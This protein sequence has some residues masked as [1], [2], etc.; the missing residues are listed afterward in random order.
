MKSIRV[1]N[2]RAG[3]LAAAAAV[4]LST[5]LPAFASADQVTDRSIALSSSSMEATG[6]SYTV[7]FTPAVTA[8]AVV[9][10]FCSDSPVLGETC[11]APVGFSASSAATS[12]GFTM[13]TLTTTAPNKVL[14]TGTMTAATPLSIEL[15]NVTNPDN[16]GTMYAR[17]ITYTD[18]TGAIGYTSATPGTHL[19]DGGVALSITST[20]GVSGA[21]LESMTFCVSG[22]A[23]AD[24]CVTTT[25]PT[26]KLGE[27]TGGTVAL[28]AGT[29]SS[30]N[31]YTQISTNATNGAIVNLKSSAAGCGGLINS[32]KPAGCY[33]AP[34]LTNGVI[35]D[36]PATFGVKTATAS[37]LNALT[38][39]GTFQPAAS[40]IYNSS[41]YALNY[42]GTGLSG[43][44]STYGDPFLD[45]ADGPVNTM[46][47]TLT[48]AA[49]VTNATPAG[50]YSADL[51]MI[52]TGKY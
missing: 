38:S 19:D 35:A 25:A 51:S 52:A 2:Y 26:L 11:T 15:T 20:V 33:I 48:F 45:T 50:N 34:A 40:S 29:V 28:V 14:V 6:V 44:T 46:N 47:M 37:K 16:A 32:S 31:I 23:I 8:G 12:G 36:N 30:G 22:A 24:N 18:S 7:N 42:V 9:I 3:Y 1:F 10:D 49:T 21:V 41:T 5:F 39:N 17:I 27:P 13:G 4:L 43:I